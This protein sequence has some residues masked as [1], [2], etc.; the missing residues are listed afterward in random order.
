MEGQEVSRSGLARALYGKRAPRSPMAPALPQMA[1]T[2]QGF[3]PLVGAVIFPL[4]GPTS[5]RRAFAGSIVI[6][7]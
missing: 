3:V 7:N 5:C 4:A 2:R 6:E 1:T